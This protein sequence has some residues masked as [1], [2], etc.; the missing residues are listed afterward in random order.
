[1]PVQL[2]EELD[3]TDLAG[4]VTMRMQATFTVGTQTTP[5]QVSVAKTPSWAQDL[6]TAIEAEAAGVNAVLGTNV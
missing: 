3:D 6:I 2:V 1:M 4:N 5:L